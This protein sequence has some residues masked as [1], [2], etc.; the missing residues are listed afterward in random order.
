MREFIL[1]VCFFLLAYITSAQCPP[2]GTIQLH[3]QSDL[4]SFLLAYPECEDLP[5][6][7]EIGYG[8]GSVKR[9]NIHDLGNLSKLRRIGGDLTIV[10]NDSL[11]NLSGLSNIHFIGG[12]LVIDHNLSL[13]NVD[14]LSRPD[15]IGGK[16]V[17]K[18]N[19]S[20]H[21]IHA[22]DSVSFSG[23]LIVAITFHPSC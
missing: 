4:D 12:S 15:S 11:L 8:E 14:H 23:L 13:Q 10:G 17:I 20:L 16:V 22:L 18:R 19:T 9:T 1:F 6:S 3:S 21:S 7:L 2:S 5:F